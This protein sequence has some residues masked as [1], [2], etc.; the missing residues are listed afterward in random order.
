M[1]ISADFRLDQARLAAPLASLRHRQGRFIGHMEALG[2]HLRQEAILATLTEDVISRCEIEGLAVIGPHI[3]LSVAKRLGLDRDGPS[4][5]DYSVDGPVEIQVDATRRYDEPVSVERLIGW[6]RALAPG[7]PGGMR[8]DSAAD[9]Q[10]FVQ[11]FEDGRAATQGLDPVLK[12]GLAHLWF[13]AIQPFEEANGSIALALA[14]LALAR[15][16]RSPR[17]FYSLCAQLRLDLAAYR[18]ILH[19]TLHGLPDVTRWF[20]WF[21]ACLGRALD[22][23]QTMHAGVLATARFWRTH[24]DLAVNDRQRRMIDRLLDGDGAVGPKLTTSRWAMLAECSHDTALR[25]ILPLVT[26]GV[27]TQSSS[28]GRSTSYALRMKAP[29]S[30]PHRASE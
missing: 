28:G 16:E 5:L 22:H 3:R 6:H 14:D 20:E 11:W 10:A 25:D 17:R 26:R 2:F 19:Q 15:S 4:L 9:V 13:A 12:A 7:G 29:I 21:L 23:A 8:P 30:V 1:V 27:L 18:D 24:P